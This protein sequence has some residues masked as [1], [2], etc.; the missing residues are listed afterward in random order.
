MHIKKLASAKQLD[1][2][3]VIVLVKAIESLK[4]IKYSNRLKVCS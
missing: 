4:Y 1:A 3:L 2:G